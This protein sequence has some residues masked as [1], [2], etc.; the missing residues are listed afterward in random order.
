M[1]D[2]RLAQA[3]QPA[4]DVE[5]ALAHLLEVEVGAHQLGVDVVL[6]L[7]DQLLVVARVERR[8]SSSASGVVL[9]L[10]VEQDREVALAR[11]LRGLGIR[12]MNSGI[13]GPLPIILTS[14]S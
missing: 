6:L 8:R 10:A 12:S 9:A 5:Q 14:A 3:E 7:A 4:G 13:A 11:L 1:R 2:G